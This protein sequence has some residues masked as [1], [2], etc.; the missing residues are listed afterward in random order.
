MFLVVNTGLVIKKITWLDIRI[1][2][3]LLLAL[4]LPWPLIMISSLLPPGLLLADCLNGADYLK[5]LCVVDHLLEQRDV[6][7]P[8]HLFVQ[9]FFLLLIYLRSNKLL[10]KLAH[11]L[12]SLLFREKLRFSL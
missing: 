8:L 9:L 5:Y 12:L 2:D 11:Y 4:A 6:H 1:S 7:H 10:H 3:L